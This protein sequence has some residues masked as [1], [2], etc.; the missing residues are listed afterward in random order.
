MRYPIQLYRRTSPTAN[1]FRN[2][3]TFFEDAFGVEQQASEEWI[4]P[5]V[6]VQESEDAFLIS[7]DI[8]G[9]SKEDVT[10]D[11]TD[12]QLSVTGERKRVGKQETG[13]AHRFERAYGKS[14]SSFTLPTEV[15][16]A[17]VEA[18]HHDGVLDI[19]IPKA[20]KARPQNIEIQSGKTGFLD[21]FLN[22]GNSEPEKH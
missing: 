5:N 8:P 15:A 7:F 19:V 4:R 14:Q 13:R 21:R 22:R 12:R 17:G 3:D 6:D 1:F 20:A 11:L 10:I 16:T 9:V 2:F 18:H